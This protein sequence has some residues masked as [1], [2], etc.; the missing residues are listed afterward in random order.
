MAVATGAALTVAATPAAARPVQAPAVPAPAPSLLAASA[1]DSLVDS[2]AA[3]TTLRMGAADSLSRTGVIAGTRGLQYVTYARRYKGLPVVGGDVVITAD[4]AGAV[5][6]TA[7]AATAEITVGTTATITA[8]A[9]TRTARARLASVDEATPA[10]LT[11]LA[12]SSPRL[13]WETVVSGRAV[14]GRPSVLHVYVDAQTGKVVQTRDDVREGTGNGFYYGAVTIDTSG[15]GSSFS[16]T[17][18]TRPGLACGGQ[19]GAAF[20]G[21]DDAWGNGSGTDLET[22]C[23]DAL[24]GAQKETDMLRDW[25][26]RSSINGDGT[27]PPIRVGLPQVNAF[28]NGSVVNFGHNQA[29]TRQATPIDVVGHELGHAIFQNTPG[30]AGSGNEN[31]GINEATG[32]IFGALSEAF[33]NSPLDPPDY[34]IGEEVDLV[35]SGPIRFMYNPALGGDPSCFSAANVSSE[36]HAAAGPLNHWFYLLAE[37]TAP[38]AQPASPTCNSS[39]VTGV[40]IRKAGE[41]YYNA[42]LA[43]TSSWRYAN[44]RVA[45]LNAARN[46]YPG[47]CTE[48]NT[49]KAAWDAISLPAQAGEPT[50]S[51]MAND[52]PM[53][54][55]PATA[56]VAAR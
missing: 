54:A 14:A 55:W 1:A 5:R 34:T 45:T 27:T 52:F 44:V 10:R 22:A 36:V 28:W 6:G 43:K 4:A 41:I 48:F 9:A 46:L 42:M 21:A 11:V 47:S 32:D 13:V 17:D 35:G 12:G 18:T 39:A 49:V 31:G 24:F 20:T 15:S 2:A 19:N 29:G 23:V 8:T 53:A 30:G 51:T 16:M 38:T 33:A 25:L 26:G 40:G 3:A 37:G 7:V 50:C 56:T